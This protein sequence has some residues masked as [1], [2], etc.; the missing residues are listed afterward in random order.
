M[1]TLFAPPE[2]LSAYSY[3]VDGTDPDLPKGT[4][5]RVFAGLGASFPLAPFAVYRITGRP[6]EP[7]GLHVVDRQG[8]PVNALD[9]SQLGTADVTPL[10]GDSDVRRTI[11]VDLQA[12]SIDGI[13]AVQLFDQRHRVVAERNRAPFLFS[14]PK[15]QQF[16]ISG[17]ARS[18]SIRTRVVALADIVNP[19]A[20]LAAARVL[21]LPVQGAHPWYL[22]V[23]DRQDGLKRVAA[24]APIRLGPADRPDG[25][26]DRVGRDD[27]I[28]RVEAMLQAGQ[29]AGGLEK[30][31]SK[32]VDDSSRE[33]WLQIEKQAMPAAD[34][35]T[36]QFAEVPRLANI[37]MAALDPGLARFL[38]FADCIDDLPELS[39][40]Q[41]WNA[42]AVAGLFAIDLKL[43][44]PDGQLGLQNPH[45]SENILIDMI[46]NALAPL[47]GE[48]TSDNIR[49]LMTASRARG[50]LVRAMIAVT[51]PT[52]PWLPPS[53]PRPALI[54]HHWQTAADDTP[55][56]RYRASLAFRPAP[57]VSLAA[58]AAQVG[59]AWIS[60]HETVAVEGFVPPARAKPRIIGRE[61]EAWSTGR[62][63]NL[64]I[65]T[66]EP[67]GLLADQDVPADAGPIA[68]RCR[69]SDFFGRFG[70]A[71]EFDVQ[72]PPRPLPPP[73][74][75]RYHIERAAI[76]P[77]SPGAISPGVLKL[78]FAVPRPA[79]AERFSA[80]DT[81]RLASA[82]AVPG[83]SDLAA[84]SLQIGQA[85][86]SLDAQSQSTAVTDPGLQ[87]MAFVLPPLSP[88]ETRTATLAATFSDTAGA[89]SVPATLLVKVTDMRPPNAYPTG[90]GLFWTS[91]PGPSPEVELKLVW[92]APAGSRHRV[93][94]TDQ[95]GLALTKAELAEPVP[96]AAASR[97]RVAQVGGNKVLGGAP[98]KRDGFR[99]L[100][101]KP[102]E[103]G[104]DA[105][106][107][108][109]TT[110]PRSLATVQ[111]LRVVPLSQEGA[112]APFDSCGIVP[113]AVPDSRRP[114]PPRL[115]GT[116]DPATG[117][118]TLTV[119]ADG[120][121][122]T[123]LQRD[124]PG[125]FNPG[126]DGAVPP[127]FRIRRAVSAVADPV[128]GRTVATGPLDR[129][130]TAPANMTFAGTA[131]DDNGGRGLQPFV[132]YVYWA[133]VR[134]PPERRLPA[135][136]APLD[137][138]GGIAAAD[139][140]NMADHIRP[141]SPPSAA[142]ILMHIPPDPPAAP[143]PA[144]L[145]ITRAA[146]DGAGAVV[147]GI[148]FTDPP[149]AHAKATG[150]YR[151]AI[152][153]QWTDQ[154]IMPVGT[155]NGAAL[156]GLWPGL[157]HAVLSITVAPSKPAIDPAGPIVLRMA[158]VDPAGR[159]SDIT[160]VSI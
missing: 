32:L 118:A 102:I 15:L 34:G 24:G 99:L 80:A 137:P 85:K 149:M 106:A 89:T 3:A 98:I 49:N 62:A 103:S 58:L 124:E 160:P 54:Q 43:F 128:F 10:L 65:N 144:A 1:A 147:L 84:G 48:N 117:V 5:L 136:V 12:D 125:L 108:L 129:D 143:L 78:T 126:A 87:E 68:Y 123:G 92:P 59:G 140:G 100:T 64:E 41:G 71:T 150:P 70:D 25:P 52:P 91:A 67:A 60:R 107:V 69:A 105:L 74:V 134:L 39:G 96:G 57:L 101:D 20:P 104:P 146:P 151:L 120:F 141:M 21:G 111:F 157:S 13:S 131:T 26:F 55:S 75:L 138:A 83:I 122:G 112:E 44:D 37:Q 90:L 4:H 42:L 72:P 28:A 152:W 115:S 94:V 97:G 63:L 14:A 8:R 46:V 127:E 11:R 47:G 2:L 6:A 17:P 18:I 116:V 158:I 77:T 113:V 61:Q 132:R 110:L 53:L 114:P 16:R 36:S 50:L 156:N 130:T 148:E 139:P 86:V 45:P 51:A 82:V 23:Q 154:E 33:P 88:Q 133:D 66:A 7:R 153:S 159:M 9:L 142:R 40:D 35:G 79:P 95:Q 30:L 81:E 93:Y 19:A 119:V 109:Q 73:P 155:V 38:G 121:D 76:D 56:S 145:T 31:L 29:L 135:G 27:E 22:G